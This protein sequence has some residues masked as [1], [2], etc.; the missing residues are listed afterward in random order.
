[1]PHLQGARERPA[2]E[3]HEVEEQELQGHEGA[4]VEGAL[5]LLCACVGGLREGRGAGGGGGGEGKEPCGGVRV[6]LVV[7]S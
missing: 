6:A 5:A 2:R 1:V 3:V 7:W 4:V